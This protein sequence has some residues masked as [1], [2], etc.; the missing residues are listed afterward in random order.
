[1]GEISTIVSEIELKSRQLTH[2]LHK[3]TNEN[4][5]LKEENQKLQK[6]IEELTLKNKTLTETNK[7][8]HIAGV[9][10]GKKDNTIEA[11]KKINEFVREI[12][13]CINLLNQ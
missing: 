1:M 3:L 8:H 6:N 10:S 12:D 4:L 11:R 2:S 7:I 13:K 5:L 9:V